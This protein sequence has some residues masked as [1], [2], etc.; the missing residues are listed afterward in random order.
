M[1]ALAGLVCA[2]DW[3]PLFAIERTG[4]ISVRW[5]FDAA[6]AVVT[7]N[8]KVG[9]FSPFVKRALVEDEV[10]PLSGYPRFLNGDLW[11]ERPFLERLGADDKTLAL[12]V[13]DLPEVEAGW[14][15]AIRRIV[16]D[17]GHGGRDSG[18]R[19]EGVA[20]EKQ[21]A[22]EFARLLKDRLERIGF[23]VALT[24][25]EDRYLSLS[26]R[27]EIADRCRADLLLS[28]HFN[29]WEDPGVRGFEVFYPSKIPSSPQVGRVAER[30]NLALGIESGRI[31]D[32]VKIY[33]RFKKER[34]FQTSKLLAQLIGRSAGSSVDGLVER[35]VWG[36]PF[37]VLVKAPVPAVLI[38]FGYLTNPEEARLL[39]SRGYREALIDAVVEAVCACDIVLWLRRGGARWRGRMGAEPTN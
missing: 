21:L 9:V 19:V 31:E 38:E 2:A 26:D 25:D 20:P 35:G 5:E 10:V 13:S 14:G 15:L 18:V 34:D 36:A 16:I 17:P 32:F 22:L 7:V 28:L 8:G 23:R 33:W 6:K 24:R 30:E 11:I 29:G 1:L 4:A 27:A 3:C 12:C 37:A 39:L